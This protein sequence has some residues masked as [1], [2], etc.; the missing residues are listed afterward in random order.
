MGMNFFV[1][2]NGA[3]PGPKSNCAYLIEDNWDDF[4]FKTSFFLVTYNDQG[5]ASEQGTVKIAYRGQAIGRTA[6]HISRSFATLPETFFSVG[7][8]P[9]YYKKIRIFLGDEGAKAL[10]RALRDVALEDDIYRAV[11][12]E[13]VFYKSLMR[14]ISETTVVKQYRRIINTGVVLTD[15]D[16]QYSRPQTESKSA[17]DLHFRVNAT[18]SPPTNIH[19]LIGRNGVGKTS[20]LNDIIHVAA[21]GSMDAH[22]HGKLTS[23]DV[24]LTENN[25]EKDYFSRVVSVSFSAF[26]PFVPPELPGDKKHGISYFYIGLKSGQNTGI[27]SAYAPKRADE[28]RADCI[29]SIVTCLSQAESKERWINAITRLQSDTNF[30]DLDLLSLIDLPPKRIAAEAGKKFDAMSSGHAI[31]L[32]TMSRLVETVEEKTLVLMDEPES[33]LHPPLLSAFTRAL[34][35]LLLNRNGVAIIATHSPVVLQEVPRSCV[36]KLWR[37]HLEARAERPEGE[38]FGE[39]VGVLTREVFGLEV[40]KSGFL[41]MLA[42]SVREGGSY[43]LILGEYADQ[44]G[45]EARA[46]LKALIFARDTEAG[47]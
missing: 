9:E 21:F 17:I 36:W 27:G 14:S 18:S 2:K 37:R 35:D 43:E 28:L 8:D 11:S 6:D 10:L 1:V 4:G 22:Q 15:F 40:T 29:S 46:L 31:V 32:L 5:I 20:L 12:N 13:T 47:R 30:E 44:L 16:F 19:V 24:F 33:H 39:N 3:E 45:F 38:T 7:Q 25:L 41:D 34:A 23:T 42:T 26:D